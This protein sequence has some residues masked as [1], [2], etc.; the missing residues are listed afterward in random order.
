MKPALAETILVLEDCDE[1]FE[2]V[3][4]A[5]RLAGVTHDFRRVTTGD[6]CIS[7]LRDR[8]HTATPVLVLLD[9]NTP[10]GDGR[11][12]LRFIKRHDTLRSLPVVV[13]STSSNPR[14]LGFCFDSGANAY[15]IKP[16]RHDEHLRTLGDIFHYW[17]RA[18]VL[19]QKHQA[20]TKNASAPSR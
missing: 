13:L 19:P 11:E 2:T 6:E 16:V 7:L 1:D 4:D 9:L 20:L 18:V 10:K 5:A 17:L 15:H 12:A 3:L 14:D 8:T